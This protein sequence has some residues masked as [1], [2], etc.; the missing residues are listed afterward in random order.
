V[1]DDRIHGD[2]LH[3][4]GPYGERW[5]RP[6]LT[7]E[8]S[9]APAGGGSAG[10]ARPVP[11]ARRSWLVAGLGATVLLSSVSGMLTWDS[12]T[13]GLWRNADELRTYDQPIGALTIEG[14]ASD[15]EVVGGGEP[16]RVQ[17]AR[18][19]SWGPGSSRPT[20]REEWSGSTLAIDADCTGFLGWCSVDYVVTV[21]TAT[22]VTV[23][24]GS[25]DIT[26]T[27][28]FGG[29]TLKGG[30]GDVE[31]SNLA[32]EAVSA[33]V[34]SGDIDLEL[35]TAA[36]PV[37][38]KTGSGDVSVHVPPDSRYALTMDA[39]SGDEDVNVVTDPRSTSTLRISTGS[40]D[41]DVDY[42]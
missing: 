35:A 31:A 8:R 14:G 25:G 22:D 3:G 38:V 6:T 42:R 5:L 12:L 2:T 19:L 33:D 27:G 9:E 36:S 10:P 16:G 13:G 4:D 37:E 30:S 23:D 24:N 7:T 26:L 29:V 32:A 1:P 17:V 15:I 18:H 40:G 11:S 39:G 21:P 20:P 34:G 28:S 41:I